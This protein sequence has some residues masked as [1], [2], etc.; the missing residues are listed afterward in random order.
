MNDPQLPT[1]A[2][3]TLQNQGPLVPAYTQY[4]TGLQG[5]ITANGGANPFG[6]DDVS[7]LTYTNG[8][9]VVLRGPADNAPFNDAF[10]DVRKHLNQP[11]FRLFQAAE[12]GERL[13][14]VLDRMP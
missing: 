12:A 7:G 10:N 13:I 1:W 4:F 9:P 6:W 14:K 11:D 2:Q 5:W 3:S 8:Q